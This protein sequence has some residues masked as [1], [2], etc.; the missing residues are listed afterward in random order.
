MLSWLDKVFEQEWN[1][2]QSLLAFDEG[3]G[4]SLLKRILHYSSVV[5]FL[6]IA[7]TILIKGTFDLR[8][9]IMNELLSNMPL[10]KGILGG[11]FRSSLF[12]VFII[13]AYMITI[14]IL[15]WL[16]KGIQVYEIAGFVGLIVLIN[17]LIS[18]LLSHN[19]EGFWKFSAKFVVKT[20][21]IWDD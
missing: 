20:I 21:G 2:L 7:L 6:A 12:I 10:A 18:T 19:N 13:L 5:A 1:R 4:S 3:H 9:Y 14:R 16:R 17:N 8:A 15:L 11:L